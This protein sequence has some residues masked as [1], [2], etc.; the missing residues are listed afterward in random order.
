MAT[1]QKT[2]TE[3]TCRITHRANFAFQDG[4]KINTLA[5]HQMPKAGI[6]LVSSNFGFIMQHLKMNLFRF[7]RGTLARGQETSV[8]EML[9]QEGDRSIHSQ[10]FRNYL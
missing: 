9:L 8:R 5:F 1:Y 6:Y 10:C 3:K 2:R 4:V 7:L